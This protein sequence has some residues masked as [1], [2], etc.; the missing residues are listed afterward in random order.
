MSYKQDYTAPICKYQNHKATAKRRNIPFLLTFEQW[1]NIWQQSG[2]WS[3]RGKGQGKYCMSRIGDLGAY[4]IGNVFIQSSV[5][6]LVDSAP[7]KRNVAQSA[8]HIAKRVASKAATLKIKPQ[9]YTKQSLEHIT[10]RIASR[11]ETVKRN[12]EQ[13]I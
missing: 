3:D 7:K 9:V 1:W 5:Q 8:E 4:E 13:I 6:N 11:I 2:H 12:K 10:K